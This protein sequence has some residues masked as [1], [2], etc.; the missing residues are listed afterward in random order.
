MFLTF[1]G[2]A[3]LFSK[4]IYPE[5]IDTVCQTWIDCRYKRF[6]RIWCKNNSGSSPHHSVWRGLS[7]PCHH[8]PDWQKYLSNWWLW[9]SPCGF[10]GHVKTLYHLYRNPLPQPPPSCSLIL[11]SE[12]T[13]SE[14]VLSHLPLSPQL[15]GLHPQVSA[16]TA[17]ARSVGK[18]DQRASACIPTH[19]LAAHNVPLAF[20]FLTPHPLSAG[21]LLWSKQLPLLFSKN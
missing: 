6:C 9:N 11:F 7:H 12:L 21:C 17:P 13:H 1:L 5:W 2:L 10:N 16:E 19:L 18:P 20:T 3:K 4:V 14:S 8:L 15:S